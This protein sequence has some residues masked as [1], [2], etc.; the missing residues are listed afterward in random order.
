MKKPVFSVLCFLGIASLVMTL[1]SCGNSDNN[2]S[3][4]N[5][6]GVELTPG[7]TTKVD[8]EAFVP[9]INIRYVDMNL[10]LEKYEYAAQETKK[11]QQKALELQQL[12]NKLSA[13][14]QK[15][16]NDIQQKAQSNL[17]LSQ[18][19]YE[20]DMRDLQADIQASENKYA[21]RAQ[22][23]DAEAT[24][25][26]Q[27]LIQTIDNF[28]VKYNQDKHYDAILHKDAGAYFNPALDITQEIID[29]LNAQSE[30]AP[31]TTPAPAAE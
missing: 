27:A 3:K 30:S 24:R 4:D 18:E 2:E 16:Q 20:K 10:I 12:Q 13:D 21:K 15:K 23:F 6:E 5:N 22:D 29:G 8:H 25:V 26:Q 11:M 1:N 19:S 9:S 17:Y 28:I 14:L 31:A 7:D